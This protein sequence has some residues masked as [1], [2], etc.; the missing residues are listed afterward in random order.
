MA[1]KTDSSLHTLIT[2]RYVLAV[3]LI[4]LLSSFAA[5]I[6]KSALSD[7]DNTAYLVN[8]SGSQRMLS[9]HIALDIHR[10]YQQR[11]VTKTKQTETETILTQ[12]IEKMKSANH[13]LASGQL[14]NGQQLKLSP[15]IRDIYFGDT[16]LYDRVNYY[17]KM[18]TQIIETTSE[19]PFLQIMNEIDNSSEDL[20]IDLDE[21]VNQYQREGD[22]RLDII[23][24]LEIGLWLITLLTLGLE[25]IFIFR[26]MAKEVIK[27]R[28]AEQ[29]LLNSLEDQV[30]L[31]TYKLEEANKKLRELASKDPLTN[32]NNRLTLE[33]DIETLIKGFHAHQCPFGIAL[34]DI[35]FFKKI[36]DAY[37]HLAGDQVLKE[38]AT[39]LQSLG[40]G[41][42][43]VYRVGGEEFVVMLNRIPCEKTQE[44]ISDLINKTSS[45]HF[46]FEGQQINATISVG[47]YHTELFPISNQRDLFFVVDKALYESKANGRNRLT[48]ATKM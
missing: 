7:V 18:A 42:D 17:L 5:Y 28:D 48:L 9:Q 12:H 36:N 11:F 38:F 14:K 19:K 10:L 23:Q 29:R 45:H 8:I 46:R 13:Q 1:D 41:T 43:K 6:M 35:D 40:R 32:L 20:L 21:A 24:R 15:A 31:R 33:V 39:I 30:E 26:P 3:T 4:A 27:S 34:I 2:K 44:I 47:L 22:E 25:V 37:G 16:D